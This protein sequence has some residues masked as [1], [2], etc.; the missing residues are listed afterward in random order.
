[1]YLLRNG[2]LFLLALHIC[3]SIAFSDGGI[4]GVIA[5]DD[6]LPLVGATVRVIDTTRRIYYDIEQGA[7]YVDCLDL[8]IS[9]GNNG[10]YSHQLPAA[11]YSVSIFSNSLCI[12]H[13]TATVI[14]GSY[15]DID[16]GHILGPGS[17]SGLVTDQS[18]TPLAGAYVLAQTTGVRVQ[19]D[20]SGRYIITDLSPGFHTLEASLT[21]MRS[22]TNDSIWVFPEEESECNFDTASGRSLLDTTGY[23][24]GIVEDTFGNPFVGCRVQVDGTTLGSLTDLTGTYSIRFFEPGKY[25]ITA[26]SI[27]HFPTHSPIIEV[28]LGEVFEYNFDPSTYLESGP[29]GGALKPEP[30]SS[31]NYGRSVHLRDF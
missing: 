27:C 20:S 16:V 7:M 23:I 3:A 1:M 30:S 9:V 25:T 26:S 17:I 29:T 21:G 8:H 15:I 11:T 13:C 5:G 4:R 2:C 28:I 18:G 19:S 24:T 12:L 10:S 31:F 14:D 6:G 22:V